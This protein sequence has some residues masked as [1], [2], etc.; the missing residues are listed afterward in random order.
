MRNENNNY[1]R[2]GGQIG[3][4]TVLLI[5]FVTLKLAG[6]IDWGWF[7]VLTPLWLPLLCILPFVLLM[8]GVVWIQ[9][10]WK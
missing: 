6:V 4:A 2:V 9:E 8:L 3:F 10:R 1:V 7:A 5:T